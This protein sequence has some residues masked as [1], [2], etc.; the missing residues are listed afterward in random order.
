MPILDAVFSPDATLIALSHGPVITLWDA[1]SNVMRRALEGGSTSACIKVAFVGR[2]GRH[3]VAA[4]DKQGI[5][6]WDLLS[7][8]S[9]RIHSIFEP[10]SD[11]R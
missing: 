9:E 11:C 2:D 7:C 4:G 5:C 3:L 10:I 6:V 1:T 8:E